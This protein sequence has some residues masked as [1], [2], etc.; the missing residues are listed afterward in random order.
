MKT[1]ICDFIKQYMKEYQSRE[2]I[3]TEYGEPLVGFADAHHPYIQN[4]PKLIGPTHGL[5]QDVLPDASII[6]A[7]YIP[8]TRELAGTNANGGTMASTEWA[9]AYEE[10]N[11]L[12][13]ELNDALIEFIHA[14]A[15]EAGV[16]PKAGAF[17]QKTLTSDWSQ[18]HI[19][20]AAGLGTFGINNMLL[21]KRGCCGRFSSVITNLD[22]RPDAPAEGE[23]CLYK[24][25]GSCGICMRNC[26][27]GALMPGGF[28]RYGCY[29]ICMENA[30]VYT[31][32]GRS[33]TNEESAKPNSVGSE[34]CGKCITGSPCAFWKL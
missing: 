11:A 19:A 3:A 12:F 31:Q 17:S 18:R 4:L 6:I 2:T 5:P 24:K 16:S 15:A 29:E 7:Y 27:A 21:T 34:V 32:F 26:P 28:D 25:N 20:Y 13:A 9:R 30:K 23:N 22:L 1:Q 10:T 8:F 14:K 33:Y